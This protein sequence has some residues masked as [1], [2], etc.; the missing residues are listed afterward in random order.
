MAYQEY[1]AAFLFS[2][3]RRS[4]ALIRK[5]KPEWQAGKF[6]GIGGKVEPGET[7]IEAMEREFLEEAGLHVTGWK[8]KVTLHKEGEFDVHFY[9]AFDDRVFSVRTM[10][11]EVVDV[12]DVAYLPMVKHVPNLSWLIPLCLEPL[13]QDGIVIN[14]TG[15]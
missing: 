12:I 15:P 8:H 13:T 7:P 1:V 5:N 9:Y 11:K 4:V 14:F 3:N 2:E 6:N 10:E